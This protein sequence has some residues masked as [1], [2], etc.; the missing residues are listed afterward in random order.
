MGILE[1]I[2]DYFGQYVLSF[3][4]MIYIYRR[5]II[6]KMTVGEKR[7][8]YQRPR[9][10]AFLALFTCFLWGSAFPAIKVG[11]EL[12][13]ID[14]TGSQLLF[15]GYRFLL[16]GAVAL[17][18]VSVINKKFVTIRR[19]SVPHIFGLGL[20]QTTFQYI[21]FYIGLA[22]TTASNGSIINGS[23]AFFALIFAHMM[24]KGE[25]ITARAAIGCIVGFMGVIAVNYDGGSFFSGDD[26]LGDGLILISSMTYGLGSVISKI[27]AKRETPN[28][29]AAY[30]LIFGGFALTLCGWVMGG[31]IT[32]FTVKSTLVFV[33]LILIPAV[34]YCLWGNL[35]KYN[36]VGR[37]SIYGFTISIFGVMLSALFL[38]ENVLD[39]F[40]VTALILVSAGVI[41][42]NTESSDK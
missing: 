7:N 8:I 37:I 19:S 32:G 40:T 4:C 18:A 5:I 11:Y 26:L 20:L 16:G 22:H 21:C 17:A 1:S 13:D 28:A 34:A 35:L 39:T 9:M 25:K 6:R 30:Q 14:D 29:I 2:K 12:F 23:N 24:M 33:Y 10:I 42:V 31:D 38:G 41:T 36:P 15:A 27:L 3:I